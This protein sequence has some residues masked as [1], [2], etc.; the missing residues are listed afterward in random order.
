MHTATLFYVF[1][2][3]IASIIYKRWRNRARL[4]LPPGPPGLAIIGNLRD[5]PHDRP[6]W[7]TYEDWARTYGDIVYIEV[8]GS[9]MVTF[10]LS[11]LLT[12]NR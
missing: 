2:G 11:A 3:F 10:S 12:L 4:P 6:Q 8:F 5:I 1:A 7:Q 9:S